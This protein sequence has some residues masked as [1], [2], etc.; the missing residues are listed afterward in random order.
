MPLVHASLCWLCIVPQQSKAEGEIQLQDN[1]PTPLPR[2]VGRDDGEMG[3]R[4]RSCPGQHWQAVAEQGMMHTD[5]V[6][7]AMGE[8]CLSR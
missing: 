3:W 7:E 5:T 1:T 2:A 4:V 6:L 8:T